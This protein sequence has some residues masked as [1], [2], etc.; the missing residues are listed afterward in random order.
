[1]RSITSP[2]L[3]D[4]GRV[5]DEI[6][7]SI[8]AD[9]ALG[10]TPPY[11]AIEG[12]ASSIA[13]FTA[14]APADNPLV[15]TFATKLDEISDLSTEEK[16]DLRARA[17]TAV[18]AIVYPAYARLSAALENLTEQAGRDAGVWRLGEEGEA[19]YQHALN[20]YGA[21]GRTGEEIHQLGL[22]EV[23]RITAEMDAIMTAQG[24]IGGSVAARFE[25]IGGRENMRYDK[26]R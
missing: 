8:G 25:G 23:A 24:M 12:V 13:G 22:A 21:N 18:E 15:T 4:L 7:E 14:P 9:A 3:N 5:Y 1:M 19:F 10:V 16:D 20:A 26:Y 6:V 17:A 11:F 2:R